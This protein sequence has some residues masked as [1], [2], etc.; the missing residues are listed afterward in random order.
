M[1][2]KAVASFFCAALT[3]AVL[4][5]C[6]PLKAQVP[7]P[8]RTPPLVPSA[9]DLAPRPTP[10]AQSPLPDRGAP[11]RELDKPESDTRIDVLRY[12]VD[13]NAPPELRAALTRLTRRFTGKQR[14]FEDLTNAAAEV[15]RFVQRELGYYLGYA[16]LPEQIPDDG[17]VRIALLEGRLDRV[18]LNWRT[19]LPVARHVV[20]AYLEQ[21]KPGDVL[22]ESDVERVV[23]L[24]NDL[25]GM[26]ARFEV[27]AGSLPGSAALVVT[28]SPEKSW[29]G[30]A[31]A[32]ANGSSALGRLRLSGLV[33]LNSPTGRGDGFTASALASTT[34]G[35]GFILLNYNTPLGSNGFKV[36]SSVSTVHYQLDRETFPLNLNG[37]ASTANLYGLMPWIRTRNL[38]LFVLA[39]LEH[40]QY[41]DRQQEVGGRSRKSVGA[42]T[43]GTTGDFRDSLLGG[44]VSS[45]ELN[46]VSGQMNYP[47]GRNPALDDDERFAKLTYSYTR[48]QDWITNRALIYLSLRGQHTTHNLD[49]TEQLRLGGPD[50]VRAFPAGQGTGDL[51]AVASAELR[52]LP[53]RDWFGRAARSMVFSVFADAGYVRFRIHPR[54]A[55]GPIPTANQSR[56]GGVGAGF[57][58]VQSSQYSVRLSVAKPV[59]GESSSDNKGRNLRF[60]VQAARIFN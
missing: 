39:S 53:P 34:G 33:Q 27:R 60:F 30:K 26:N 3:L 54:A 7:A 5:L 6:T 51:G 58:W 36:G 42:L 10:E 25:R 38:N 43:L 24:V 29:S 55:T 45:Y 56:L 59:V 19:D 20:E 23:F 41:Q 52:L 8:I 18:I 57:N 17:V 13:G 48:L 35:L 50:G 31:E 28:P 46:V 15:T 22:K 2:R 12:E 9:S 37:T 21:L 40:K 47:D 1:K 49:T 32:D 11:P 4:F 16:Y 44:G 14:S